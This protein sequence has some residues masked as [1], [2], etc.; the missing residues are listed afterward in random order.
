MR[1]MVDA[2]IVACWCFPDE[3]SPVADPALA[4]LATEEVIVPAV[5]LSNAASI[6]KTERTP[7]CRNVA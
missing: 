1:V 4:A 2:S 5:W 3:A 6:E 7:C